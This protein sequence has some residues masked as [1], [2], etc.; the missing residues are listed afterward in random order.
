MSGDDLLVDSCYVDCPL[1]DGTGGVTVAEKALHETPIVDEAAYDT[2]RARV[3]ELE[4]IAPDANIQM[5]CR[6]LNATKDRVA[7]LETALREIEHVA[8]NAPHWRALVL[9][10][11]STALAANGGA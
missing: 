11:A 10:L 9:F 6:S 5:L 1:C 2:M 3:A 4:A 7:A 8:G